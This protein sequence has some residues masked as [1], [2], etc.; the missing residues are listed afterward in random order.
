MEQA[1]DYLTEKAQY[2]LVKVVG[3]GD[4]QTTQK[5]MITE[6]FLTNDK[7]VIIEESPDAKKKQAKAKAKK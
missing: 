5:I 4:E 3:E 2:I 1:K 7:D 6:S